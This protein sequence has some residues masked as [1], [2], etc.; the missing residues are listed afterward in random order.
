[1]ADLSITTES[2][3]GK[4]LAG[5]AGKGQSIDRH[6]PVIAEMLV[7]AVHDVLEAEGPGWPELADSTKRQRRGSS[8]AM[9]QDT[10]LFA[11]SIAPSYGSTYAEAVDGT[12]YGHYHVTGTRR[13]P[14]RDWSNLGPYEGP[15]LD[16]VAKMLVGPF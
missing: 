11:S 7:S 2:E 16:E 14:P 13:M 4:V 10:G 12:T 5:I 1:M 8:Y 6:L 15:L 3:L 9:L